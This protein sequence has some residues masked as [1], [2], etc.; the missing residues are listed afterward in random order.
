MMSN[1]FPPLSHMMVIRRSAG[2][3]V[4]SVNVMGLGQ[5]NLQQNSQTLH[6]KV[7]IP[8]SHFTQY[9]QPLIFFYS[10][11]INFKMLLFGISIF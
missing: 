11:M 6:A 3:K 9:Q 1:C 10:Y 5:Q 8:F 4:V 2:Q 7:L